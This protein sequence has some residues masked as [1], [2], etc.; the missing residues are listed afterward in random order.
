MPLLFVFLLV[1]RRESFNQG[2]DA[3]E[4]ASSKSPPDYCI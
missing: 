2:V 1:T 4:L 3:I